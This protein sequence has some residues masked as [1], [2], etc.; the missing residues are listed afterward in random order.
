MLQISKDK[1]VK[2]WPLFLGYIGLFLMLVGGLIC[3]PLV[4]LIFYPSESAN[5]KYFIV[6][7]LF[8]MLIG[9][10][11][12]LMIK[13]KSK[14]RLE[15]YQATSLLISIWIIAIIISSVPFMLTGNY[16]FTQAVFETTSGYTTT[17]LSVVNVDTCPKIFLFYRSVLLFSGG[18]GLVLILSSAISDSNGIGLYFLE[19]H[20][21]RLLP[22]LIKS[23][24][25][26]FAIYLGYVIIGTLAYTLFGMPLFDALNHSMAALST[27]GFSTRSQSI[28]YYKS[29]PI[30]IITIILMLLGSTNFVLHYALI[31]LKFKTILK[32]IETWCFLGI[33]II[34]LPLM[35]A[36]YS[37]HFS[38]FW[39]GVRYGV[40]DFV[41][42][43]TTTGFQIL[44][45]YQRIPS[46]CLTIIILLMIIGGQS[47]STAGGIKQIRVALAVK[48]IYWYCISTFGLANIIYPRY[49]TRYGIKE[50]ANDE[51]LNGATI[52]LLLYIG[53]LIVG[54]TIFTSFGYSLSDSL[55]EFSSALG[56]VGLSMGITSYSAHPI[57]LWTATVGMFVGRLE[58]FVVIMQIVKGKNKIKS[59]IENRHE[60]KST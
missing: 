34:F 58:I 4:M 22:N 23:A 36:F 43:A 18:I 51:E 24:R 12:F 49:V 57:I 32:N 35:V 14:G 16:S 38:D 15:K 50:T 44:D 8:S 27:G 13:G 19:G 37:Y 40:F 20:N 60:T 41:T 1:E 31:R 25:A 10:F 9:F 56:T 29:V 17:G 5:A 3:L 45:S 42:A 30:E 6:T 2:G 52:Y 46:S 48:K 59:L 55:F 7:G 28:G 39:L 26:I 33:A 21:D 54:T 11:L 47:G 53:V